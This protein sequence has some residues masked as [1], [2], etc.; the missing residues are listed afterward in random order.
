MEIAAQRHRAELAKKEAARKAEALKA[1][2]KLVSVEDSEKKLQVLDQVEE[3]TIDELISGEC[4]WVMC[5]YTLYSCGIWIIDLT[6][7]ISLNPSGIQTTAFRAKVHKDPPTEA[8][9]FGGLLWSLPEDPV[10]DFLARE[11]AIP[12][13]YD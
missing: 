4:P 13:D 7:T 3:G 9:D 10:A 12:D 5:W 6:C 2:G 8:T 11:S 1:K